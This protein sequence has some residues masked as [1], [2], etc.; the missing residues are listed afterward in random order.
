MQLIQRSRCLVMC[1]SISMAAGCSGGG[2]SSD[3]DES[4]PTIAVQSP[5]NL[6]ADY[7]DRELLLVWSPVPS[8]DSYNVYYGNEPGISAENYAAYDGGTWLK[9]VSAPLKISE[10]ENGAGYF[11]VVTAVVGGIESDPSNEVRALVRD[12]D[13]LIAGRY[14]PVN[15]HGDVILDTVN[16][17]YWK[18]CSE[19]QE[20]S[21]QNQTCVGQ[22]LKLNWY[23][24]VESYGSWADVESLPNE[25]IVD[26]NLPLP[27]NEWRLPTIEQLTTL[28]YC[29]TKR[30]QEFNPST[31]CEG[32]D[33]QKPTIVTE[34][35]PNSPQ[36]D[37]WSGSVGGD[38]GSGLD[39]DTAWRVHFWSGGYTYNW[40]GNP[41]A[42]RLVRPKD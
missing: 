2:G 36:Y 5:E 13:A 7:G 14:K 29:S 17:L 28:L 35:F 31:Y 21:L 38:I 40:R 27:K 9:G 8:A 24:A 25:Y 19:G 12:P 34:A 20:W 15:I 10:L 1:V 3:A 32:R 6:D 30:P 23:D 11:A 22:H 39:L 4:N 41:E 37:V 33:Y 16:S 42:I 26:L 18:R